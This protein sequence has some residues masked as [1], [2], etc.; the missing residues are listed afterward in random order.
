MKRIVTYSGVGLLVLLMAAALITFLG[1]RF[2]WRVDSVLSGSME[3]KLKVGSLI[4]S[5]PVDSGDVRIGD[6]ITF[7]SP[8]NGKLTTHQVVA[9]ANQGY[10]SFQTKGVAN[11]DVDPFVI[12]APSLVGKVYFNIPYVGYAAQFFKSRWSL[13]VMLFLPGLAIV[14]MEIR[15][16]WRILSE[17][18]LEKKQSKQVG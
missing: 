10:V 12:K 15:K 7:I 4:L 18:E 5:H 2:G 13:F 17:Q 14:S 3:P 1:P 9:V 11:E 6:V 16:I 8:S